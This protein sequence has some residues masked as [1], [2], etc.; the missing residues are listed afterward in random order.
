M[1]IHDAI[2]RWKTLWITFMKTLDL[3]H[4]M[5]TCDGMSPSMVHKSLRTPPLPSGQT[6]LKFPPEVHEKSMSFPHR[7]SRESGNP[8]P[9]Q[10]TCPKALDSRLRGN[11]VRGLARENR[12]LSIIR[13][14]CPAT[15]SRPVDNT[16]RVLL[17]F[18]ILPQ[19]DN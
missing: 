15:G 5:S 7:H 10:K 19:T 3:P 17:A 14:V 13:C 8:E 12:D 4:K 1:A 16:L 6:H 9:T 2:D 11:D 18:K